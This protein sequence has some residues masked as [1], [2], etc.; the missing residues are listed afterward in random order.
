M[1]KIYWLLIAPVTFILGIFLVA[2][3]IRLQPRVYRFEEVVAADVSKTDYCDLVNNPDKYD[4]KIVRINADLHW[5]EHGF[6]LA[7]ANCS[8]NGE[9]LQTAILVYEPKRDELY[10]QLDKYMRGEP[11]EIAAVG[12]F[13]YERSPGYSDH[14]TDRTPLHFEIYNLEYLAE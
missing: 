2:I 14:I 5:F 1:K 6:F 3:W 11:T 9:S 7:D 13:R 10:K 12:V 4:G 8:G